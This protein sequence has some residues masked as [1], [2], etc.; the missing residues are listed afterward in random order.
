MLAHWTRVEAHLVGTWQERLAGMPV[1]YY[2]Y[3]WYYYYYYYY[4]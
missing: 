3:Y 4:Y 1:N 2:H